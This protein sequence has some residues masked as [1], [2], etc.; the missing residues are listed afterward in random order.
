MNCDNSIAYVVYKIYNQFGIH[1]APA[2]ILDLFVPFLIEN[3]TYVYAKNFSNLYY[4]VGKVWNKVHS[5]TQNT[6]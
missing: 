6:H 3:G 2:F 1:G 5:M 4:L